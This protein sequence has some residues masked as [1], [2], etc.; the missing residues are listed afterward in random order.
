MGEAAGFVIH[1]QKLASF[2][3]SW[4]GAGKAVASPG[5]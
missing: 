2:L 5:K 3:W 1:G 4:S